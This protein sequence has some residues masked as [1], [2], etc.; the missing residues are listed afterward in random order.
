MANLPEDK[1]Q[2]APPFTY[3]GVDLFGPW[4][5]K[6][7][8]KEL[9]RY[10]VLFTCMASQAIHIKGANSL[11]TDC[12]IMALRRPLAI[13]G[14]IRLLRSDRGTNF[15][16]AETELKK[17]LEEMDHSKVRMFL[18][19]KGC[20]YPEFKMNAPS[21]SHTGGVWEHQIRTVRRVLKAL[22]DQS[23]TQ[24]DDKSL[25]TFMCEAVA[26]SRP[27]SVDNLNEATTLEPLTMKSSVVLP[28]PSE[29][30]CVDLYSQKRW[31]RVQHLA[32]EIWSHWKSEFLHTLQVHQPA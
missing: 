17:A 26:N 24:L 16:G 19:E 1:L 20:D 2:P 10:G 6:E 30:Q 29:F 13:R 23:G 14:P 27:L 22:M 15:A 25:R 9:K 8:R 21:A 11:S 28:P 7:G 31:R 4:L 5:T 18:T 12:F 32:N 3:C